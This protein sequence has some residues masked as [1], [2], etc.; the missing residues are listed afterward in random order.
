MEDVYLSNPSHGFMAAYWCDPP[1]IVLENH[2]ITLEFGFKVFKSELRQ[3][4]RVYIALGDGTVMAREEF[5][6]NKEEARKSLL[7]LRQ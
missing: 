7:A 5:L 4:G 2:W 6:E 3:D 1:V